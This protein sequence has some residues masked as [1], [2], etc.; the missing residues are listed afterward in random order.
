MGIKHFFSWFKKRF[1]DGI[2]RLQKEETFADMK[3]EIIMEEGVVID[4]FM[5]DMNGLFHNSTQKIYEYG[6]CKPRARFLGSRRPSQRTSGLQK[7]M[8][9]FEDVC[10]TIDKVF[11]IVKPRKK[12]ILC[13]D[14][15][16]PLSKQNQQRQRRFMSALE[17]ETDTNRTFD[18]N[19]LTPGTKFMDYLTKYIDWYIRKKMSDDNSDWSKIEVIFSNEKAPGE[20]E[21]KLIN[22]IRKY[23]NKEES[24]CIHGMDADLIML[25]L[26]T[27]IPKFWILREEP[28]SSSF[29]FYVIDIGNV[30]R[31][32]GEIMCWNDSKSEKKY[33]VES[34]IN[35]FI[36]MCFTV[37]NDFLPHIPGIEIIEGGID[38]MLDVYKNTCEIYGHITRN[39]SKGIRFRRKS[40]KAFLGTVSQY[41]KGVLQDKLSHKDVFFPDHLLETNSKIVEGK[42]D[43]NISQYREDYYKTNL[44]DAKDMEKLCHDY[45][46]GMQWVMTYYTQGVPNWKWR[47]PYHYAPF[48]H[49]IAENVSTFSFKDYPVTTPTVPFIQLLS[50]LPPKSAGLLPAPLDDL[51]ISE[52]SP[53]ADYCPE[54]FPVDLSGKRQTWEGTVILPMVDYANVEKW[55]FDR[56]KNVDERDRKRNILG[57]SFIYSTQCVKPFELHSYYGDFTCKVGI[58]VIDL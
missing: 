35:D 16:A 51:L 49:T 23:G 45:L 1:A 53:M 44:P 18:S 25:S 29:E 26:G 10:M 54:E 7:Q 2:Y 13:V 32:M 4:N 42:Y 41:E 27:H 43:L 24:Y 55:Y 58:K 39:T 20:G 34:A 38:F 52:K 56:I 30:R 8:K 47:F 17:K 33:D 11:N 19:C 3:E 46:E 57:K 48:A 40:L 21:H 9:V 36:F 31:G 12:L 6:N 15:P 37:G 22:F 14:G 50:V 28:M 5:I